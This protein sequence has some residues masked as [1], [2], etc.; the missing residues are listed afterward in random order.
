MADVAVQAPFSFLGPPGVVLE[1]LKPELNSKS[2]L[3]NLKD[4]LVKIYQDPSLTYSIEVWTALSQKIKSPLFYDGK[5]F[6]AGTT[7][8]IDSS[9]K[10]NALALPLSQIV[11]PLSGGIQ[12]TLPVYRV[13][14]S[15]GGGGSMQ[16][17]VA[18]LTGKRITI[19]VEPADTIDDVKQKIQD[20]EGIPPDQQRL[21]FAG[22][23]LED[24]RTLSDYNIQKESLLHLVLRLRGGMMHISSG[25]KD[26]CST[27]PPNA[28]EDDHGPMVC[29]VEVTVNYLAGNRVKQILF[30]M[31]P[32]GSKET[33]QKMLDM[34]TNPQYF[35]NLPYEDLIALPA[36]QRSMLSRAALVRVMDAICER[37]PK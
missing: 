7:I 4:A 18:T 2:T 1:K 15:A 11:S 13:G 14:R 17:F 36:G 35:M 33:L 10:S 24:G 31:H 8:P 3:Q 19:E 5:G 12:L 32:E 37:T 26:Y 6:L 9:T 25:R 20:R 29:P 21:I 16:I 27:L 30:Y 23:Q 22:K 28:R 34:E